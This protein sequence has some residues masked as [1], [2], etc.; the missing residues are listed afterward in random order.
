MVN[1]NYRFGRVAGSVNTGSPINQGGNQVVGSGS[2]SIS[3]DSSNLS[4]VDPD[5]LEALAGLRAELED[6]R[7]TWSER[8]AASEAL[9]DIE[10]AGADKPA[11]A[12]AFEAFL[13]RLKQAGALAQGGMEF[14]QHVA[15]LVRWLGPLAG[16]ALALL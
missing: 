5:V 7:L 8:N 4:G 10:R 13:R 11:A 3:G 15:K 1:D 16:G 12:S 6:L 14:S 2:I 9:A